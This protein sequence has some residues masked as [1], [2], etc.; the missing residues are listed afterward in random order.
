MNVKSNSHNGSA[1]GN[2]EETKE[3][4]RRSQL[5]LIMGPIVVLTLIAMFFAF[6]PKPYANIDAGGTNS[7]KVSLIDAS[8]N[9]KKN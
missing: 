1:N 9:V 6:A 3:S 5:H 8:D 2:S 4:S 7:I